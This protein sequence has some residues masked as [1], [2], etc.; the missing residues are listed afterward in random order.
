MTYTIEPK[1]EVRSMPFLFLLFDHHLYSIVSP[2]IL[3]EFDR[4]LVFSSRTGWELGGHLSFPW[5]SRFLIDVPFRFL[6]NKQASSMEYLSAVC[7]LFYYGLLWNLMNSVMSVLTS[8]MSFTDLCYY[9]ILLM[10]RPLRP[11]ILIP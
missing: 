5:N 6:Q 8:S 2:R 3:L 7:I 4:S 1:S 10:I 9:S 11:I